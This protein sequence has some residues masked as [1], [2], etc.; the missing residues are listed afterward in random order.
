M[1]GRG[2]AVLQQQLAASQDPEPMVR[3]WAVI[4]LQSHELAG[5]IVFKIN[6]LSCWMI[7]HPMCVM[8]QPSFAIHIPSIK[9][10][11]VC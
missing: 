1:T 10:Q 11:R 8:K 7:Q 4:G 6:W 3:Y 2:Q 9:K 5:P